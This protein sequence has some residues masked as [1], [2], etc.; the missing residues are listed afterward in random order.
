M[1]LR[2]RTANW[3]GPEASRLVHRVVVFWDARPI[4]PRRERDGFLLAERPAYRVHVGKPHHMP[5]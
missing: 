4:F 5:R 1:N 2:N 3:V